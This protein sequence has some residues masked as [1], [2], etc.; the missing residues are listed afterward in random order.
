[1]FNNIDNVINAANTI[2]N[3][4]IK[5]EHYNER[6]CNNAIMINKLK[7]ILYKFNVDGFISIC[8][9]LKESFQCPCP[10]AIYTL[11][12]LQE[13][14]KEAVK[15]GNEKCVKMLDNKINEIISQK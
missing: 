12:E 15:D 7:D 1:M 5:L 8:S 6:C 3:F 4:G 14:R 13:L 10:F 2:K 9:Q 11:E